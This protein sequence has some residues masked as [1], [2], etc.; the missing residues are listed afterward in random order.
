MCTSLRLVKRTWPKKT[1]STVMLVL[2]VQVAFNGSNAA[3]AFLAAD[4]F[5]AP[6]TSLSQ[7]KN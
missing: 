1:A 4:T 3:V 5:S 6:R 2:H 7:I